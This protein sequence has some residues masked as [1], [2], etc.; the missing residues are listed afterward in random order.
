MCAKS[1]TSA[2]S[3]TTTQ[4]GRMDVEEQLKN[5]SLCVVVTDLPEVFDL[6]HI[7]YLT[8]SF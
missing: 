6:A 4:S 2:R 8:L 7:M 5:L 1:K 3:V